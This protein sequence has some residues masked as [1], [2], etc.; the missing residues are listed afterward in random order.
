[1]RG[2][3]AAQRAAPTPPVVMPRPRNYQ[4]AQRGLLIGE[5]F[6]AV[7]ASQVSLPLV[8]DPRIVEPVR[9]LGLT[10]LPA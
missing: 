5:S 2:L 8:W 10:V 3:D 1:V 9:R 7:Q 6:Q 4:H